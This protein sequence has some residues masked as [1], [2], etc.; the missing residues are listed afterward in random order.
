MAGPEAEE[1]DSAD[2]EMDFGAEDIE[3]SSN[4]KAYENNGMHAS[5]TTL[6]KRKRKYGDGG[7]YMAE[8]DYLYTVRTIF[9]ISFFFL[10]FSDL[11]DS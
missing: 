6:G 9:I 1:F 5:D 7:N 2:F 11:C 10:S 3:F 4:N 8:K